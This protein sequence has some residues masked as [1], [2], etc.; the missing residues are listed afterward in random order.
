MNYRL[1]LSDFD[2]TL[3]R[4]DGTVS[5]KN[6][7]AIARYVAAGGTFAVCTGRSLDSILPRVRE[8]G[9]RDGPVIAF[10]GAVIAEI[11]TGK[12]LKHETFSVSDARRVLLAAEARDLH[13]HLY[14]VDRFYANRDDEW[15][16]LYEKV[17]GVK[18]EIVSE[19][20]SEKTEREGLN[21][22]KILFMV[23]P[24]RRRAL[25]DELAEELGGKFF[26][27]CSSEWLVEVMPAAQNKGAA[28]RFLAERL[29]IPV[30][31]TAAIGDQLNDLPMIE[32]AGG[33][34]TVRNGQ[35][36]LKAV[37]KEV[38]SNEEDGVAEAILKYALGVEE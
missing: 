32:A 1:F 8:L 14:T 22:V 2:G 35:A 17:V 24:E 5:E 11:A 37:A 30:S 28:V 12:L 9:L 29:K 18:A 10:Q 31:E 16:S 36:E 38:A 26:V 7:R 19:P 23:E 25:R 33:K 21:V 27:T 13:T 4:S 6:K 15:L 34:F 3:V 20:F